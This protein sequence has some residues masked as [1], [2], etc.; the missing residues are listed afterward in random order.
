MTCLSTH[1]ILGLRQQSTLSSACA[2]C[3][4]TPQLIPS[5]CALLEAWVISAYLHS[6]KI[7]P[8]GI[9]KIL[10]PVLLLM[11]AIMA[12]HQCKVLEEAI[13]L[14]TTYKW[15]QYTSLFSVEAFCI[16]EYSK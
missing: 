8:K 1:A 10:P 14:T 16:T 11:L 9:A 13:K 2:L 5:G 4:I 15:L 7:Q 12:Y 6:R 3:Q